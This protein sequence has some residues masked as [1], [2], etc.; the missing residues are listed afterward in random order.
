MVDATDKDDLD[1]DDKADADLP[2]DVGGE[3]AKPAGETEAEKRARRLGWVPESEWDEERAEREGKRKPSKFISADE[4]IERTE[5]NIPIMR[6]QLRRVDAKLT[7]AE[8]KIND[9]HGVILSQRE[10]TKAAVKRAWE[11]GKS[12]A[13]QRMR[14]AVVEADPDKYDEAKA[15]LENIVAAAPVAEEAKPAPAKPQPDPEA[16]RWADQNKWFYED[17]ELNVSMIAEHGRVKKANPDMPQWEQFEKAK[18][19]VIRRFPEKFNINPRREAAS[20]VSAPS[21]ARQTDGNKSFDA[22][23]Q[24][25]RDA[26]ER[27]RKMMAAKNPPVKYTKEEFMADY[28]L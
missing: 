21:G 17:H 3:A 12:E 7:D 15:D 25:D 11:K 28:A 14:D 24:A 6:D 10:M 9:M 23:P 16:Q 13:E 20:T 4:F 18:K 2:D 27:H 22:I 19:T 26:Y 5:D 8:S 1:L